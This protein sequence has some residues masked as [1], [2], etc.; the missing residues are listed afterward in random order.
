MTDADWKSLQGDGKKALLF[1][2]GTTSTTS[3][4]F[5][6][7]R[8]FRDAAKSLYALYG[9]RVLGFNHHTLTLSVADNVADFYS[10]LPDGE[11]HFDIV[12]HSR[13]GLIARA[14]KELSV[15]DVA[16]LTTRNCAC[17]AKVS[18][19]KIVFVGTPNIGTQLA[20][21]KDIPHALEVLANVASLVPGAGLTLA[22]VLSGAAFVA[23]N[24]FKALP[25]MRNMDPSDALLKQLN[26]V[27][28][29]GFPSPIPDYYAVQ[30]SFSS[31]Q[32]VNKVL[33]RGVKYRFKNNFNDLI[34]PTLGTS[35]I[36][37]SPLEDGA[38]RYFGKAPKVE[39]IAHTQY[40]KH[41]ETWDFIVG[42]LR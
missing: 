24:G 30:S 11:F 36:D 1:I 32:L 27:A 2:H 17:S 3:G 42:N 28:A 37:G 12:C 10:A 5:G 14:I 39:S 22:G 4:A 21:P 13:G 33:L 38:V 18:I 25:G 29:G 20:D 15:A 35:T 40:F 23:E 19:G 34:V 41:P 31:T 16:K 9:D 26:E 8:G 6:G 7:L